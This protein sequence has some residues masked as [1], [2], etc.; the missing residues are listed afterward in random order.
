MK[1]FEQLPGEKPSLLEPTKREVFDAMD[2]QIRDMELKGRE[3]STE[4]KL[5]FAHALR[6]VI[7]DSLLDLE[8]IRKRQRQV[9]TE[10]FQTLKF[11]IQE[12]YLNERGKDHANV[13]LRIDDA[14]R[15]EALSQIAFLREIDQDISNFERDAGFSEE[16]IRARA[17]VRKKHVSAYEAEWGVS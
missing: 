16:E 3:P 10:N 7:F 17:D 2:E 4:Q 14:V 8:K 5:K 11:M 1:A 9:R 12:G 15:D 13:F 6:D